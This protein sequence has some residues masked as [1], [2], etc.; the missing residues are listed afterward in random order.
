MRDCCISADHLA[1][2]PESGREKLS[3]GDRVTPVART[4][5]A[6]DHRVSSAFLAIFTCLRVQTLRVPTQ[7]PVEY[8]SRKE[9]VCD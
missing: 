2:Y 7:Q 5:V 8:L 1:S 9:I 6:G 3:V 4:F